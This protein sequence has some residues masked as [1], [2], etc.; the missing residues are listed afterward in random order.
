MA[1]QLQTERKRLF[2]VY[3]ATIKHCIQVGFR[4]AQYVLQIFLRYHVFLKKIQIGVKFLIHRY[5]LNF[6]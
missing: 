3:S 1:N 6:N 4:H 2:I 5:Y